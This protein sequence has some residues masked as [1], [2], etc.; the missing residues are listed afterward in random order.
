[1][2]GGMRRVGVFVDKAPA[3]E[4]IGRGEDE[5]EARIGSRSAEKDH[6]RA[7]FK[8]GFVLPKPESYEGRL[9][10]ILACNRKPWKPLRRSEMMRCE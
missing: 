6:C 2:F 4:E 3:R 9:A 1:M 5:R 8:G 7:G 10:G